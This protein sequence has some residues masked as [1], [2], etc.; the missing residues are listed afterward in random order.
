[1]SWVFGMR[2][3]TSEGGAHGAGPAA[4]PPPR[5]TAPSPPPPRDARVNETFPVNISG[6]RQSLAIDILKGWFFL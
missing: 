1:M 5:A 2:A 6:F 4:G 3:R